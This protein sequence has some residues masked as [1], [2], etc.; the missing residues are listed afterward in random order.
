SATFFFDL[1]GYLVENDFYVILH[2][3]YF[4]YDTALCVDNTKA[5]VQEF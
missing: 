2:G 3:L 4:I 1:F 5:I